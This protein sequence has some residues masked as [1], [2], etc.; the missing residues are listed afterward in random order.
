MHLRRN[1]IT[2][3]VDRLYFEVTIIIII[4]CD[5]Q[6][7]AYDDINKFTTHHTT[8]AVAHCTIQSTIITIILILIILCFCVMYS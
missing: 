7:T 4:M 5:Q 6:L 2:E 1:H 8:L 3:T